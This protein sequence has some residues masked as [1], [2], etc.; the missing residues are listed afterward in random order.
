MFQ[1][2]YTCSLEGL[3]VSIKVRGVNYPPVQ[4]VDCTILRAF[5]LAS[6]AHN[7]MFIFEWKHLNEMLLIIA[8]F[9]LMGG[10]SGEIGNGPRAD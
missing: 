4:P 3:S 9:S 6:W 7:E 5:P 8:S 1:F 2:E 10:E